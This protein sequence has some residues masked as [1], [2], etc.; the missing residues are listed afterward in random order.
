MSVAAPLRQIADLPGPSG[1]PLI[2]NALQLD[3]ERIHLVLED[4]CGKYGPLFRFRIGRTDVL[5]VADTA[6]IAQVLRERPEQF[7][8]G[9]VMSDVIEEMGFSNVFPA[10][11]D[12]WRRQRQIWNRAMG[13]QKLK[14]FHQELFEVTG[15]L[16]KRWRS[17][18]AEGAVIDIQSDLMLYTVDV[19]MRFALGHDANTLENPAG[20]IQRHLDKIFPALGRRISSVFPYWRYLK[21]PADREL[22][23]ALKG[24][25]DEV[26]I[27]IEQAKA[28]MAAHPELREQPTCLLEALLV[29]HEA[30]GAPLSE[31]ELFGNT[32]GALAAGEDTTANTI[33]W[34]IYFIAQDADIQRRL[35]A[36]ADAVLAD[37]DLLR[38]A[39]NFNRLPLVDA[40][41]NESLRLKPVAPFMFAESNVELTLGDLRIPANTPIFLLLRVGCL[42]GSEYSQPKAFLPDRPWAHATTPQA[43]RPNMPFGFGPR[44]CPG[45]TLAISEIRSVTAM[46]ARNFTVSLVPSAAPVGE[47]LAFTMMPTNLHVRLEART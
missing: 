1:W 5:A 34:M 28:R 10:E 45:R 38:D 27:L 3:T 16:L 17:A 43:V 30:D 7:R 29:A 19:T 9:A 6:L 24:A 14:T 42:K 44:I 25:Y 32:L 12:D 22:D 23:R 20:A 37:G 18:A 46:L 26:T 40:V 41:M 11:G 47:R 33:A 39:E 2:G 36:E 15:R 8:R 13:A 4:W 31:R 35:Q 21:L